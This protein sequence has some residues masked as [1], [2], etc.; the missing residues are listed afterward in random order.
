MY[1]H[2]IEQQKVEDIPST[3]KRILKDFQ[4][5]SDI[6]SISQS[7]MILDEIDEPCVDHPGEDQELHVRCEST[8]T[9]SIENDLIVLETKK[10]SNCSPQINRV[11]GKKKKY[12]LISLANKLKIIERLEKGKKTLSVAADFGN[13]PTTVRRI[14]GLKGNYY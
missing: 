4:S 7:E 9:K 6:Q 5:A 11:I 1:A 14:F 3:S 8:S 13:C 12:K 10:K 2:T